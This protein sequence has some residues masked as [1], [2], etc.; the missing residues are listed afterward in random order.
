M[1][2]AGQ[3]KATETSFC[4]VEGMPTEAAIAKS[5][6]SL[7]TAVHG[8]VMTA[9]NVSPAREPGQVIKC[10]VEHGRGKWFSVQETF[11][12]VDSKDEPFAGGLY[13]KE[14]KKLGGIARSRFVLYD[15]NDKPVCVAEHDSGKGL[16]RVRDL[17][18]V[19][20]NVRVSFE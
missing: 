7:P 11:S 4:G 12:V 14:F 19:Q 3:V 15:A 9:E 10:S 13:I 18:I 2:V 6:V 20:R 17:C 5:V 1:T 8:K 16:K